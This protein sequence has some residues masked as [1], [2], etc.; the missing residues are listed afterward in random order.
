VPSICDNS[1]ISYSQR[2]CTLTR[3]DVIIRDRGTA[4]SR[5]TVV[6][7]IEYNN[8]KSVNPY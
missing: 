1:N 6:V 7:A 3:Q 8:K 2:L 5:G 4:V